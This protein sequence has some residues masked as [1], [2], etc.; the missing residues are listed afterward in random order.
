MQPLGKL[1]D[2]QLKALTLNLEGINKI[3]NPP[4]LPSASITPIAPGIEGLRRFPKESHKFFGRPL[5]SKDFAE[6]DAMDRRTKL[7]MEGKA[8]DD[9]GR[10]WNFKA[11]ETGKSF[12]EEMGARGHKVL[13]PGT[14]EYEA[15]MKKGLRTFPGGKPPES[16]AATSSI[17][18]G[19]RTS[20]RAAMIKLLDMTPRGE[21]GVGP[22]L[23][24]LLS[25]QQINGF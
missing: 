11:P 24:E 12:L 5:K 13:K 21:P 8:P 6:I 19:Q 23:R 1:N 25:K 17:Q 3:Y 9:R 16:G 15:Y 18:A 2:I 10:I 14:P 22:T 7:I 20:A 4:V